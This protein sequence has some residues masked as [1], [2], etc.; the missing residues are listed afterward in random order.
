M[1]QILKLKLK[2][3]FFLL[4][5]FPCRWRLCRRRGRR[6]CSLDC[7]CRGA[8]VGGGTPPP[9]GPPGTGRSPRRGVPSSPGRLPRACGRR[10]RP[11][12]A[13]RPLPGPPVV[14]LRL[15]ASPLPIRRRRLE[16]EER[17]VGVVVLPSPVVIL[18]RHLHRNTNI[19][20]CPKP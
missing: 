18:I 12:W 16:L 4:N 15:F 6:R 3:N 1:K 17:F 8:R 9:R 2:L 5:R 7:A 13:L 20:S 19:Q 10:R 11:L 14:F